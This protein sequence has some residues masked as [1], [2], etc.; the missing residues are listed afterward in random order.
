MTISSKTI[1]DLKSAGLYFVAGALA[2]NLGL[3]RESYGC[4]FGMRSELEFAKSEF[5][6]GWNAA[7]GILK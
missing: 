4:H 2:S 5:V 1:D 3:N 7:E 6:K